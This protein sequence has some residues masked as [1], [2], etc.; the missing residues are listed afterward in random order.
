VEV[1]RDVTNGLP[2]DSREE[3]ERQAERNLRDLRGR[4]ELART[5]VSKT[6][7]LAD[8]IATNWQRAA[9]FYTRFEITEAEFRNGVPTDDL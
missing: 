9:M 8:V 1:R 4:V 2:D 6:P 7:G 3:D 5:V